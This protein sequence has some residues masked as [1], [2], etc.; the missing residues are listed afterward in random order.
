VRRRSHRSDYLYHR[1]GPL[2]PATELYYRVRVVDPQGASFYTSIAMI[3]GDAGNRFRIYPNPVGAGETVTV[4]I[5]SRIAGMARI[6]LL[7]IAGQTVHTKSVMLAN[8]SNTMSWDIPIGIRGIYI[9]H[10][11]PPSGNDLFEKLF[12]KE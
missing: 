7:D 8:G 5:P 4:V 1:Y 3:D 9:L 2:L 6:S 11:Q 10:V 12:V